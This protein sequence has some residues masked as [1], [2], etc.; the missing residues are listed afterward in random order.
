MTR[1]LTQALADSKIHQDCERAF[2]ETSGLPLA[3][4]EVRSW[5]LPHPEQQLEN[6][7]CGPPSQTKQACAACLEAQRQPAVNEHPIEK[8]TLGRVAKTVNLNRFAFG[9]QFTKATGIPFTESLARV[10]IERAKSLL[11]NPNLRVGEIACEVG[12]KS[13]T[14]FNRAFKR[15]QGC[16]PTA[17]RAQ[18]TWS[19]EGGAKETDYDPVD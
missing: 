14:N 18:L 10:R 9:K 16:S 5:P 3:P 6:P 12:F 15:I 19:W 17:Y 11:L 7:V 1:H 8:L 4:R 2:S 13:L